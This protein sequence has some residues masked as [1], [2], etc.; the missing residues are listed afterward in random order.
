MVER[1]VHSENF[2]LNLRCGREI[3]VDCGVTV[4]RVGG[5]PLRA[6]GAAFLC[7]WLEVPAA[8]RV[9]LEAARRL[10][11]RLRTFPTPGFSSPSLEDWA[12]SRGCSMARANAVGLSANRPGFD[13]S[14]R[15][16]A[17]RRAKLSGGDISGFSYLRTPLS[18]QLS[19][20]YW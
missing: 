11:S 9:A 6:V 14:S 10:C 20:S 18:R 12:S 15:R 5:R 1:L 4:D 13:P 19:W 17:G 2:W 3:Q 8:A 7:Q 16:A